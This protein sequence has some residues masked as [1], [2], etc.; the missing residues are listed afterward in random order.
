MYIGNLDDV[1][2]RYN[3]TYHRTNTMNLVPARPRIYI[4]FNKENNNEYPKFKVG[5]PVKT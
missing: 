4:G 5:Y 2:N 1:V 3:N